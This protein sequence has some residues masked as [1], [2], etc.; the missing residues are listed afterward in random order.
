MNIVVDI[1]PLME[2]KLSGIEVY[3]VHLLRELLAAD[4]NNTY[5]LFANAAKDVS[6]RIPV[7]SGPNVTFIQ[8]RIPNKIL[9]LGLSVFRRPKLDRLI[10]NHLAKHPEKVPATMKEKRIDLFFMPDL[11]PSS[12]GKSVKKIT[13]VHD[14][15][16]HHFRNFFSPK[17][18][19]WYRLLMPERE[20]R[21]SDRVIAVSSYTKN[22]LMRTFGIHEDKI[23]VVHQGIEENFGE[24]RG[25]NFRDIRNRYNLPEK[26]FLSLATLEPRKNT[27]NLVRAFIMYKHRHPGNDIKLVIAGARNPKI[28]SEVIHEKHPDII[29]TGF[30]DEDLKADVIKNALGFLYP[31]FFEGF[32]IPLLEAMKCETPVITSN[33]SSMPEV[34]GDAAL[35]VNPHFP[36]EIARAMEKIREE[37]TVARLKSAMSRQIAKFSW[38]KC[39][40]E[41]LEIMNELGGEG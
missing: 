25:K 13:V 21:N 30:I 32:G 37:A 1:R 26:Y 14:L 4:H 41:T 8:T 10:L 31:S 20:I 5:I 7:F 17:T 39:A 12:L 22:D 2:G 34:V 38:K 15:S 33:T 11:R 36:E 23:K 40:R 18:R 29:F 16:F 3:I 24:K 6:T 27:K 19:L 9:N 35:L 28:F